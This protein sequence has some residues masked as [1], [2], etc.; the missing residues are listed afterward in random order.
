LL[1]VAPLVEQEQVCLLSRSLAHLII[2]NLLVRFLD[3]V[4]EQAQA[5]PLLH[6]G[7]ALPSGCHL[8]TEGEEHLGDDAVLDAIAL[9]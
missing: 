5:I 3:Q 8:L 2:E 9:V 4:E 6:P 7:F 1:R